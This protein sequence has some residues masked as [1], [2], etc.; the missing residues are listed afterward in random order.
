M[1]YERNRQTELQ[2]DLEAMKYNYNQIR[3][4]HPDKEILPV[5]KASG[6]G[7]GAKNVKKF[8]DKMQL[9]RVATA[10]VDEGIVLRAGLDYKRR[11]YYI[12]SA[13]KRGYS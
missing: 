13:L 9:E 2:I 12:K 3:K 5:L 4:M 7:I 6:Y 10:F 8:L 1:I 11:N